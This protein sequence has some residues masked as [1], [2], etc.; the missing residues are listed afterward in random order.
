MLSN[1][2]QEV[3]WG[4]GAGDMHPLDYAPFEYRARLALLGYHGLGSLAIAG[5]EPRDQ[6]P[7]PA[8]PH[9]L[10]RHIETRIR[11][12]HRDDVLDARLERGRPDRHVA[13]TGSTQPVDRLKLEI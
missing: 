3:E 8:G 7:G 4:L 10:E 11:C 5:F 2:C 12:G 1:R 13:A 9:L 6:L